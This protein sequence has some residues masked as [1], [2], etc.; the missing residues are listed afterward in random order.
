M[1]SMAPHHTGDVG[2]DPYR[3]E[4]RSVGDYVLVVVTLLVIVGMVVWAFLG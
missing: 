4:R 3:E 1:V 2:L